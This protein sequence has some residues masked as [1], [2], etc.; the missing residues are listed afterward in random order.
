MQS[1]LSAIY[2]KYRS[3][4]LKGLHTVEAADKPGQVDIDA[5]MSP[6]EKVH[7]T[8]LAGP[9]SVG[10]L[11]MKYRT[12]ALGWLNGRSVG[13]FESITVATVKDGERERVQT[14]SMHAEQKL[15]QK[16][17]QDEIAG[18]LFSRLRRGQSNVLK[19]S[20][21]RSPCERCEQTVLGWQTGI[22]AQGYPIQ[23]D[24]HIMS[25][26]GGDTT[27]RGRGSVDVLM[28]LRDSG[29]TLNVWNVVDTLEV[30]LGPEF[31]RT[32]LTEETITKLQRRIAE[33]EQWVELI[34]RASAGVSG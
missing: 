13:R 28:S 33:L 5:V 6:G 17:V 7:R 22:Q 23:V 10:D 2:S 24:W 27:Q 31:D 3:R 4:G 32:K 14:T 29:H 8:K 34:N 21:T 9:L 26:Y 30:M 25:L 15:V 1:A 19:I 11:Q 16:L 12:V 20:V 18:S